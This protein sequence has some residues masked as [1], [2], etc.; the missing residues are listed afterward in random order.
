[1]PNWLFFLLLT[2]LAIILEAYFSM[3]EM[4]IVSFNRVRLEYFVAKKNR[5]AI[6]LSKLI[7]K[8]TY[9]FGTTLIGVNFFLQLGSES[10]RLFYT[11]LGLNPDYAI[12]SQIVLVVIFAELIP[13]FAARGHAEHV[14]ML[15]I[16]PIYFISK[17]L[18]PFVW[19]LDF[20]CKIIDWIFRS[21]PSTQNYLTRE[22]LQKAIEGK[23]D[24]LLTSHADELDMLI[25]NIFDLKG[26]SPVELMTPIDQVQMI[27]YN[28]RAEE[29]KSVLAK[30][31]YPYLPLYYIREENVIGIIYTRD[32]LRLDDKAQIR[33][34]ARSPWFITEKNSLLQIIKQFR[35]NNQHLA[36][37]L[38]DNGSA[39][40]ILTLDTIIELIF[41]N[42]EETQPSLLRA[43]IAVNRSFSAETRVETVNKLLKI[44]L[45]TVKKETLEELMGE[46]L[47]RGA[48]KKESVRI[49]NFRL[50]LEEVPLL[51]DK[52]IR[53]ESL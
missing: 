5:K 49:G 45:P 18:I 14:T 3:M 24:H 15:G 42:R 12:G 53:I 7:E 33:D 27:P 38:D 46:F 8:P 44:D 25:H 19:F 4:A 48:Q 43:K 29:V 10:A 20:I 2:F 36:V 40:G 21:P 9:L 16:T 39:S 34:I 51:A 6:W 30:A 37:V 28:C 13:L 22:E 50:T 23:D 35:W 41:H 52:K 11:D 31:Y 47:G 1:M 32:L 17:V 26:K